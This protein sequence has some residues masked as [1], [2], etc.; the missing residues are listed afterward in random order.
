VIAPRRS[1]DQWNGASLFSDRW[2]PT[3]RRA[4]QRR[5]QR[6]DAVRQAAFELDQ[7][8]GTLRPLVDLG[9][10]WARDEVGHLSEQAAQLEIQCFRC[11]P[12]FRGDTADRVLSRHRS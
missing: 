8:N 2:I 12:H 7:L 5:E 4:T 1:I 3:E 9:R 6:L 10:D 11:D